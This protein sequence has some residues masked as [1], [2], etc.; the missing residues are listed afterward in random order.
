MDPALVRKPLFGTQDL[1]MTP[2]DIKVTYS[3]SQLLADPLQQ[4]LSKWAFK[5]VER[6]GSYCLRAPRF[7]EL[8]PSN[9]QPI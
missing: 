8:R 4:V 5:F 7:L 1:R 3:E 2:G 6:L 9:L